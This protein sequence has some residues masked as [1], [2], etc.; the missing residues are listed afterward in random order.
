MLLQKGVEQ[1]L[2]V[3]DMSPT[4]LGNGR[5]R[6]RGGLRDSGRPMGITCGVAWLDVLSTAPCCGG[7]AGCVGD[8]CN[9]NVLSLTDSNQ[10]WLLEPTPVE[11]SMCYSCA[12]QCSGS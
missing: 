3:G 4:G 5:T 10:P 12:V 9:R 1:L 11:R 8:R 6:P 2:E 7:V